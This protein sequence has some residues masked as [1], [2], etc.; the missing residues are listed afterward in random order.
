MLTDRTT[1]QRYNR[2]L[3]SKEI[4]AKACS[5]CH[6]V[7]ALSAFNTNRKAPDGRFH[8]CRG[9][10][11][12]HYA[13]NYDT[14]RAQQ[15][16]YYA[17]NTGHF[18]AYYVANCEHIAERQAEWQRAN[19]DKVRAS[20]QRRRARKAAATVKDFSAADLYAFWDSICAYACVACG[21]PWEHIDHVMP[22]ALGGEHSVWNLLP[23]CAAC[24]LSKGASDPYRWLADRF[25]ILRDRLEPLCDAE[26]A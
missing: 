20:S 14:I 22:L 24:N 13:A 7:K 5:R 3:R 25:P 8:R 18:A 9:C 12:E 15:R 10:Q 26:S 1:R 21:A 16:D 17:A 2:T 6:A 23:L 19:P 4:L 11:A